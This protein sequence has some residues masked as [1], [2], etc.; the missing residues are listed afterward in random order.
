MAR[1][2]LLNEAALIYFDTG[3][4]ARVFVTYIL[5]TFRFYSLDYCQEDHG[6]AS[7][8]GVIQGGNASTNAKHR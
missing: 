3:T 6:H 8:N 1:V 5:I 2:L 4:Q 7:H